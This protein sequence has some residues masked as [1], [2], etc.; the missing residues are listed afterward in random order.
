MRPAARVSVAKSG[1]ARNQQ[2]RLPR[3]RNEPLSHTLDLLGA[4]CQEVVFAVLPGEAVAEPAMD[5]EAELPV[6]REPSLSKD[7]N[8]RSS[9]S[10]GVRCA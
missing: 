3:A 7:G 9:L 6:G 1:L 4:F 2:A 10:H 8:V 5:D